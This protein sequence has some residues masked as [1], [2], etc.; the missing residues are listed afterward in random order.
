MFFDCIDMLESGFV[1]SNSKHLV[2]CESFVIISLLNCV[3]SL[4]DGK[5]SFLLIFY[6][7]IHLFSYIMKRCI[8]CAILLLFIHYVFGIFQKRNKLKEIH[9]I[10]VLLLSRD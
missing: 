5:G 8:R 6:I 1:V 2:I 7:F 9:S 3:H 4:Q 10:C